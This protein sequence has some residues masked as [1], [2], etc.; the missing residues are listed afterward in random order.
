MKSFLLSNKTN[1]PIIPWGNLEDNIFYIGKV[2]EG[3]SL[4]VSPGNSNII[5]LDVDMK[6]NKNG[7][8]HI[9]MQISNELVLSF[10][11]KTKSG[12]AHYFIHYTGN[13]ILKNCSTK[14]G[15]DLRRGS[16]PGNAGGYVKWHSTKDV[17][18]C[19]PLI[20]P[21]SKILNKWL[22]KLFSNEN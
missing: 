14:Y 6:N 18:D 1:S 7:Y 5:I 21:S 10:H 20:K 11:Y 2:P 17:R 22:E 3:Y 8:L 13:K 12:G 16:V 19:I 9:P 4:A 15:L